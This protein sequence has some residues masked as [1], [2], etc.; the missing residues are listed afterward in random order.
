VWQ[1]EEFLNV[2]AGDFYNKWVQSFAFLSG[3]SA[4]NASA[5]QQRAEQQTVLC[6]WRRHCTWPFHCLS[7]MATL[8]RRK[9]NAMLRKHFHM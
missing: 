7:N 8:S 3:S 4:A 1:N 6:C 2:K 5:L 9:Q